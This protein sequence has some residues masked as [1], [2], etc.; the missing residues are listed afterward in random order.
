MSDVTATLEAGRL[1]ALEDVEAIGARGF[2]GELQ[3]FVR[4]SPLGAA[5]AL[6]LLLVI[7]VGVAAPLLAPYDPLEASYAATR[8][9]PSWAHVLGTDHLGRDTL[10]RIIYGTRVTMLVAVSSVLLGEALGFSWG[11]ASGYLVGRFDI[12]GQRLTEVLLSFPGFILALLLLVGLGSGLQTVIVA[13]AVTRVPGTTRIIR[14][15][16]LAVR[17]LAYVEAARALGAPSWHVMLRHVAP[18][19]VAPMLVLISLNLGAAIF[20][21]AGLSFLG[22]GVPPPAPSWGNMLGGVLAEAFKPPWWMVL[23]PGLFLTLTIMA[24]NLLGDALRDFL[25]PRLTR[26]IR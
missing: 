2:G 7:V 4:H 22:V 17:E 5:S 21:E 13:I 19:C 11:V 1:A 16:A 23:F 26:V 12:I 8:Q 6:F 18:Q 14:S 20:I 25:D 3:R 9:P 10:S 15:V 24:T